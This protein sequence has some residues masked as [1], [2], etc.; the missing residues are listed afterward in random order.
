M[1]MRRATTL[2]VISLLTLFFTAPLSSQQLPDVSGCPAWGP[3]SP[4]CRAGDPACMKVIAGKVVRVDRVCPARGRSHIVDTDGEWWGVH[5][6]LLKWAGN[7]TVHVHLGP[8]WFVDRQGVEIKKR[9]YIVVHGA[10]VYFYG[11]HRV[12]A[13]QIRKDDKMLYLREMDGRPLWLPTGPS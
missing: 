8:S 10:G 6:H 12:V 1:A 11:E 9:D 5:I 4:I 7:D 3:G 13:A 2:S